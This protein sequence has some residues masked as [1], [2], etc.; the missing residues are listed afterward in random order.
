VR[1][2]DKLLEL[3]GNGPEIPD[4]DTELL[5]AAQRSARE[6]EALVSLAGDD[7]EDD[8]SEGGGDHSGHST[9]KALIKKKMDPKKAASMCA[10][11]DKNVK[12][13][14]LARSLALMLS[15]EPGQ[16]LVLTLTAGEHERRAAV[17]P[18]AT[19]AE[20][21]AALAAQ[22]P[23]ITVSAAGLE[24]VA[25]LAAKAMGGGGIIMNHGPFRGTHSHGHFMSQVHEHPHQHFDDNRHDGGPQHRPGSK[26]GGQAGW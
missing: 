15:G 4:P 23:G 16:D 17:L 12:A 10:R 18:P 20:A 2:V 5:R 8:D 3:T 25:G 13:S 22:L 14:Q 19:E 9:Y 21:A 11:S 6:L 7:D 1:A 26:P 24:E